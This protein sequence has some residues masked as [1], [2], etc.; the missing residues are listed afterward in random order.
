MHMEDLTD[1]QK[2]LFAKV[3]S[4]SAVANEVL[5]GS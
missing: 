3:R 4:A 2:E 1:R 5:T